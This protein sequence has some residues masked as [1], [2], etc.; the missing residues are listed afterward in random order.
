MVIFRGF[1]LLCDS[2]VLIPAFLVVQAGDAITLPEAICNTANQIEVCLFRRQAEQGV[3]EI[4]LSNFTTE[5]RAGKAGPEQV[6][7]LLFTQQSLSGF[8]E[9]CFRC[10]GPFP[11][12]CGT[13]CVPVR[14][15]FF[16]S[17]ASD[18]V[19]PSPIATDK[20]HTGRACECSD[21]SSTF[22][23]GVYD[24]SF[25]FAGHGNRSFADGINRVLSRDFSRQVV[26]SN[27]EHVSHELIQSFG[28]I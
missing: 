9:L 23:V 26:P 22:E 4:I 5:V 27:A 19:L 7:K 20:T 28:L 11:C 3:D 15:M 16:R 21:Y 18:A 2:A 13:A 1:S 8:I 10:H 14:S 6:G 25:A 24:P 12:Y 17:Q